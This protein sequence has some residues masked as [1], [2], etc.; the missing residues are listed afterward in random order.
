[1][2]WTDA[3]APAEAA[4][5]A[6]VMEDAWGHLAPQKNAIY[7]GLVQF[8]V[9]IFGCDDLNPTPIKCE[10]KTSDGKELDSS[11]RFYDSLTEFLSD[12]CS[13]D[14]TERKVEA[15]HVYEWRG[16]FRN[17]RFRGQLRQLQLV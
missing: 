6:A 4:Y 17:Y 8:A 13:S 1:M 14:P 11:P 15:G 10:L 7:H 3:F 12:M 9:G 16:T 2:S 5:R